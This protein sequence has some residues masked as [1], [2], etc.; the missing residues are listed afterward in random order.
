VLTKCGRTKNNESGQRERQRITQPAPAKKRLDQSL[1]LGRAGIHPLPPGAP[2]TDARVGTQ[3]RPH[4]EGH[5]APQSADVKL[6]ALLFGSPCASQT[7]EPV[8]TAPDGELRAYPLRA[9]TTPCAPR[10][11][12]RPI[13]VGRRSPTKLQKHC[14][15]ENTEVRS[16]AGSQAEGRRPFSSRQAICRPQWGKSTP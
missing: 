15:R 7:P 9:I 5:D 4:E 14:P 10:P 13:G 12:G 11:E 6:A 16:A 8:L 3:A 1:C 2:A